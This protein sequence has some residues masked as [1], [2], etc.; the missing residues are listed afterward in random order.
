M[1]FPRYAK[2]LRYVDMIYPSIE[3]RKSQ[4]DILDIGGLGGCIC[5]ALIKMGF[6]SVGIADEPFYNEDPYFKRRYIYYAIKT[7]NCELEHDLL[8]TIVG[9]NTFNLI[10]CTETMKHFNFNPIPFVK[11]LRKL[12]RPGGQSLPFPMLFH[13]AIVSQRLWA[14]AP[15]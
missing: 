15:L 3:E 4:I 1:Y 12:I 8:S 7:Y 13:S 10:I 14:E 2:V 5:I 9:E 11:D 6:D